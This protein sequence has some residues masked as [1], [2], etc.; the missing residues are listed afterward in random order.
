MRENLAYTFIIINHYLM[1]N[2]KYLSFIK[3]FIV[4]ENRYETDEAINLQMAG[5]SFLD[6]LAAGAFF[7][8]A[9]VSGDLGA[10]I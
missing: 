7:D 9:S 2:I 3:N 8:L 10:S 6:D 4:L 5:C 1:I